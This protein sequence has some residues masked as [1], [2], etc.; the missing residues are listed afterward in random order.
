MA[1][2]WARIFTRTVRLGTFEGGFQNFLDQLAQK[3][4]S[5]GVT[6]CFDSPVQSIQQD[7]KILKITT[8]GQTSD[9]DAVISTSSP[10]AML[11]LAPQLSGE[12]ADKLRNL[13]SI[14]AVVVILALKHQLMTDGTYWLNLPATSPDK[15][16]SEFPFLALVEHTN[17]MDSAHYGGDHIIYCGDYVATDHEYFRLSED[18]LAERFIAALK[19][20]NPDF[21]PDWVKKHWVFRAPYAQPLPTVNHSQNIPDLQTPIRGLYLASMSQVYPWDRGTNYAVRIG[22]EAAQRVMSDLA[23]TDTTH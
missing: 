13:K 12:Y 3:I 8:A 17:Y 18:E 11:K 4:Q 7:G 5:L 19:N 23:T 6:I 10:A 20:F 2:F 1:W 9:F 14:G 16:K 15:S 22:R 21:R